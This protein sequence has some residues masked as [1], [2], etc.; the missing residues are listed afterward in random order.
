MTLIRKHLI[1]SHPRHR[2]EDIDSFSRTDPAIVV[3][4]TGQMNSR[5]K[6][7]HNLHGQD[8]VGQID[9]VIPFDACTFSIQKKDRIVTAMINPFFITL[10][11]P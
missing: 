2:L 7:G 10:K 4:V 3:G 8:G 1:L 11:P 9:S 6:A 5:F